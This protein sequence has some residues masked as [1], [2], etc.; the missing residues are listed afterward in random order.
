MQDCYCTALLIHTNKFLNQNLMISKTRY[1]GQVMYFRSF[2][3]APIIGDILFDS[4]EKD[5]INEN[6]PEN[7][8]NLR[9]HIYNFV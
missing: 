6:Y 4:L 2:R 8:Y 5:S 9:L 3:S 1:C 7:E